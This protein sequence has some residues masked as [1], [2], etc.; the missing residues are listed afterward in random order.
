MKIDLYE[1]FFLGLTA[2]TLALFF[3]AIVAS[4]FA[5]GITLPGPVGRVDPAKLAETPPF[6]E[7]GVR[8]LA[9]GRYEVAMIAQTWSF[10]PSEIHLPTGSTVT[11]RVTSRDVI[12]G[13]EITGAVANL[14]L[15]P[16]HI[17]VATVT[18]DEPGEHLIIC[19]EYCGIGHQGM[20]GTIVVGPFEQAETNLSAKTGDADSAETTPMNL[21]VQNGCGACHTI[22]GIAEMSGQ[23]GPELTTIG[24]NASQRLASPGYTGAATTPEEYIQE[25]LVKPELFIVPDFPPAMPQSTLSSEELEAIVNYLATLK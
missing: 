16:G 6:D 5:V 2:F 13:F 17:S 10:I 14:T 9:P 24:S 11:F 8:E 12:H 23:V 1:R 7:P 18:F 15:M 20:F 25:S 4:T 3:F 19:H 22:E 21:L